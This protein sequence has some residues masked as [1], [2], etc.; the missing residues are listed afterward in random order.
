M[1]IDFKWSETRKIH[2]TGDTEF[3]PV[4]SAGSQQSTNFTSREKS[5]TSHESV[6]MPLP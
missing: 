1:Q 5:I 3:S 6:Q 4:A 2:E